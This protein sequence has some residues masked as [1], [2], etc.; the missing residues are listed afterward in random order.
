MEIQMKTRSFIVAVA[1]LSFV[2]VAFATAAAADYTIVP[3]AKKYSSSQLETICAREGGS[4]YRMARGTYG[5]T[6]GGNG[7]ECQNDGACRAFLKIPFALVGA[8]NSNHR[9]L[10]AELVLEMPAAP[11]TE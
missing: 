10:G 7:V 6:N 2:P 11:V 3:L 8:G 5:C 1:A 4:S 9:A